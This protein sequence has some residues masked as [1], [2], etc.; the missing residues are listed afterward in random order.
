[1]DSKERNALIEK[2]A[3]GPAKIRAALKEV[4]KEALGWR[5][6][7]AKWSVLEVVG[8]CADSELVYASRIRYLVA[9][10]E[11]LLI[12]FDQDRWTTALDYQRQPLEI[13]LAVLQAACAYTV[14]LLRKIPAEAWAKK[15]RHSEVG[16]YSPERWLKSQAEHLEIH[17]RQIERN[18]KA[19]KESSRSAKASPA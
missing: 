11:P 18:L 13:S 16:E 1:M 14:P 12:G 2:Y 3:V 4:P 7:T 17:S 5:P 15:G 9:E 6:G 10:K 19:W 8:H